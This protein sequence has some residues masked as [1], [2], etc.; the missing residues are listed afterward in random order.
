MRDDL[1]RTLRLERR[2]LDLE[3]ALRRLEGEA[4]KQPAY[5]GYSAER[6]GGVVWC[7]AIEDVAPGTVGRFI[8]F[9]V[10]DADGQRR[11]V[12]G[13]GGPDDPQLILALHGMTGPQV[14]ANRWCVAAPPGP[15]WSLVAYDCPDSAEGGPPEIDPGGGGEDP[16]IL[17]RSL[18]QSDFI[19]HHHTPPPAG[20]MR[21]VRSP[22]IDRIRHVPANEIVELFWTTSAPTGGWFVLSFGGHQIGQIFGPEIQ[23]NA[24]SA[25]MQTYCEANLAIGAGNVSVTGGPFHTAPLYIEFIGTLAATN[26]GAITD[27]GTRGGLWNASTVVTINVT[28]QGGS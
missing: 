20:A 6:G 13:A 25:Q 17:N 8:V 24:T 9:A 10:I 5:V 26:V 12:F 18:D 21:R 15:I 19:K 2:L 27:T 28:Q 1:Q 7:K 3:A 16:I 14:L 22:R 4:Q 23:W 11:Q